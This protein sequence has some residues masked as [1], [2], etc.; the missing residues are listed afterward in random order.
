MCPYI[1][2]VMWSSGVKFGLKNDKKTENHGLG[3]APWTEK[4]LFTVHS[5]ISSWEEWHLPAVQSLCFFD[6]GKVKG[7]MCQKMTKKVVILERN[8]PESPAL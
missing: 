7:K 2:A 8:H 4:F 6:F 3:E 5:H 1:C